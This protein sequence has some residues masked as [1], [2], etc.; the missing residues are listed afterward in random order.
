MGIHE[1]ETHVRVDPPF[2]SR[3]SRAH[4]ED[5]LFYF[6]DLHPCTVPFACAGFPRALHVVLISEI[7]VV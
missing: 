5:T 2:P 1:D 6:L 3:C 4:L 7:A